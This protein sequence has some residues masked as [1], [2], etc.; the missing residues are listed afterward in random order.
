MSETTYDPNAMKQVNMRLPMWLVTRFDEFG[1]SLSYPTKMKL[2]L[3]C[4]DSVNYN[5]G[6]KPKVDKT[7]P[8]VFDKDE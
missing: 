3:D 2:L 7:T 6:F 8:T 5:P 1:V 4:A